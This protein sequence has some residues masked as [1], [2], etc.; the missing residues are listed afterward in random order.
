A[1]ALFTRG[2]IVETAHPAKFIDVVEAVLGVRP[3]IPERLAS[4]MSK[5]KQVTLI[6]TEFEQFKDLLLSRSV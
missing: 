1:L 5:A 6:S 4:C 3:E 2:I